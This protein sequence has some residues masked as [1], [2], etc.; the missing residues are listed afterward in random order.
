VNIFFHRLLPQLVPWIHHRSIVDGQMVDKVIVLASRR[1][2]LT[3]V[4][5]HAND[6]GTDDN[7]P[8]GAA[9]RVAA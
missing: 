5:T 1:Y 9:K 6:N 8:M 2:P 7:F 4:L 3:M